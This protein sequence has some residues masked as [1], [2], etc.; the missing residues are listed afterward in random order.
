MALKI[1]DLNVSV[2]GIKK[3]S[4]VDKVEI[5]KVIKD[6]EKGAGKKG[7]EKRII[8]AKTGIVITPG[9]SITEKNIFVEAL[10]IIAFIF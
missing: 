1:A 2:S 9:I 6:N 5:E 8:R 7:R 10:E 3:L 4:K